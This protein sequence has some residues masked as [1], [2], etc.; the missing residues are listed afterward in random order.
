M[1]VDLS[2]SFVI[3][4]SSRA[5]FDLDAEHASFDKDGLEAYSKYQIAHAEKPLAPGNAFALV[6]AILRLNE[7][8]VNKKHRVAE[9]VV[10]S[11][12]GPET[13]LRIFRSI[14]HHKLDIRRVSLSGGAP[15]AKYLKAYKVGLYLSAHE[16]D[17]GDAL[18]A[19]IPAA[20][21]RRPPIAISRSTRSVSRLTGMP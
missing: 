9:V 21:T 7:A 6:R 3:G 2:N 15:N 18:C 20:C 5:L 13:S 8:I 4:I 16:A 12:N 10:M 14:E 1:P 17:V 11:R 19:G